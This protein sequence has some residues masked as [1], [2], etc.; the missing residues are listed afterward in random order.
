MMGETDQAKTASKWRPRVARLA[1]ALVAFLI[2]FISC[3]YGGRLLALI[4]LHPH[5]VEQT[6]TTSPDGRFDAVVTCELWGGAWGGIDWYLYIVPKGQSAPT[7]QSRAL[8]DAVRFSGG[9]I[10]WTQPH[11]LEVPY[12]QINIEHVRNIWAASEVEKS[13]SA[14]M[15]DFYVEVRLSSSS[16]DS[17]I[18]SPSG[19]FMATQ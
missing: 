8:L 19:E 1:M 11:L 5:T 12:D 15:D 9:K 10:V 6:R 7:A 2:G 14:G 13:I 16:P 18:L 17:S 3:A 4:I